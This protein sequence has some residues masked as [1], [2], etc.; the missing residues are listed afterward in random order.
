MSDTAAQ[1]FCPICGEHDTKLLKKQEV[2]WIKKCQA[3]GHG[4]VANM[5]TEEVISAYYATQESDVQYSFPEKGVRKHS[6]RLMRWL[7]QVKDK[8]GKMLDIGCGQGV[9]LEVAK[10][11]G[12][13]VVGIDHSE[14]SQKICRTRGIEAYESLNDFK[15]QCKPNAQFD[16][17]SYWEVIEHLPD[18]LKF[19]EDIKGYLKEDGVLVFS[20]PNFNSRRAKSNEKD[21]YQIRPPEHLQYFN[22]VSL[23]KIHERA[24]YHVLNEMTLFSWHPRVEAFFLFLK[25]VV[26]IPNQYIFSWKMAVYKLGKFLFD[27]LIQSKKQGETILM[28]C[29]QRKPEV[30]PK[31]RKYFYFF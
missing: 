21:W 31:F 24:G 18:P 13:N 2:Y 11:Q 27:R 17:I 5:P 26:R 29:A 19:L 15:Q 20:T 23:S 28:M 25:D 6:K 10:S 4:F 30:L 1:D 12:W 16:V 3:C 7:S 22:P 14:T 9:H 8:P